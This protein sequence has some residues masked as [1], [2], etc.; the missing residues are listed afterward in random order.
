MDSTIKNTEEV[1]D[2]VLNFILLFLLG[3]D[4]LVTYI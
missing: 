2:I 1:E 3:K 4:S